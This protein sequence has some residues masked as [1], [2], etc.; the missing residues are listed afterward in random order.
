LF[1]I[2]FVSS[3]GGS[4][5]SIQE[6]QNQPFRPFFDCKKVADKGR[7]ILFSSIMIFDCI[8]KFNF[9]INHRTDVLQ[10]ANASN[11]SVMKF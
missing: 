6:N 2:Y 11:Q 5:P 7:F 9:E 8:C 3:K 4:H 10:T 1:P